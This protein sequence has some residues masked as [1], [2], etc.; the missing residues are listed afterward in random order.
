[1]VQADGEDDVEDGGALHMPQLV[2]GDGLHLQLHAPTHSAALEPANAHIH[3]HTSLTDAHK[4]HRGPEL[5]GW[6]GVLN[7]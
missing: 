5:Q 4:L 3:T 1:M 7:T 2:L 6:T